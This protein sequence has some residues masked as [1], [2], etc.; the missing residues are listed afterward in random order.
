MLA[1]ACGG[2]ATVEM[3]INGWN[4]KCFLNLLDVDRCFLL[5]AHLKKK[6]YVKLVE[7]VQLLTLF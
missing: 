2:I 5:I 3:T 7:E 4:W 1:R 6:L